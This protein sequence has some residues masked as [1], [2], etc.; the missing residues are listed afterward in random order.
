MLGAE[1]SAGRHALAWV[2]GQTDVW[3]LLYRC[4]HY[5]SKSQSAAH[6][7]GGY[8]PENNSGVSILENLFTLEEDIDEYHGPIHDNQQQWNR[9]ERKIKKHDNELL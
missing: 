5:V 6:G 3:Y 1:L 9:F 7:G 2:L 4:A 8:A